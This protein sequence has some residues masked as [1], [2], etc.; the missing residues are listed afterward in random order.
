M[1]HYTP[2]IS[3]QVTLSKQISSKTPTVLRH[4]EQ[5]VSIKAVIF[6]ELCNFE[7]GSQESVDVLIW[8]IVGFQQRDLKDSQNQ[9]TD[10]FC[11]LPVMSAQCKTEKENYL[12][13][14]I[15]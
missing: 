3:Q 15:L 4:I 10:T 9:G 1:P 8:I 2:F 7:L 13:A 12:D 14:G 11:R 5:P 6:H